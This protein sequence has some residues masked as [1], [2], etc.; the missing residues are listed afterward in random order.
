MNGLVLQ[1]KLLKI[2]N[3]YRKMCFTPLHLLMLIFRKRAGEN[4]SGN[5]YYSMSIMNRIIYSSHVF[6]RSEESYMKSFSKTFLFE[7]PPPQK[8]N[9]QLDECVGGVS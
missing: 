8:K 1:L 2:D 5:N 3:C 7:G 6:K 4:A 9:K